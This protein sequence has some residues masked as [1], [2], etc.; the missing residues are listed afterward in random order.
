M[1]PIKPSPANAVAVEE[2][3]E[4]IERWKTCGNLE[5]AVCQDYMCEPFM[6]ER[7][8]LTTK[9][10][11]IRTIERYDQLCA[12]TDVVI[13]PVLQ[14][15]EAREYVEHIKMYEGRLTEGMRVGVGSI[16]KRNRNPREVMAVLGA[17]KRERPDLRL[18]AFGLKKTA[19]KNAY[20]LSLLHSA[21]SMAWSYAARREGRDANSLEEAKNFAKNIEAGKGKKPAQLELSF[22]H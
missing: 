20:I 12:L 5:M 15:F 1:N 18:H 21:D 4:Q 2:Y 16:C 3:A 13:M 9:Q 17:V 19:L 7:T 11:Q 6:L 10:H 22:A 8:G 14:G